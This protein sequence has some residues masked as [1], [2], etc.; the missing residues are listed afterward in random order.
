MLPQEITPQELKKRFEKKEEIQLIDVRTEDEVKLCQ[1]TGSVN[2]PLSS[3]AQHLN[4]IDPNVPIVTMCH[5]GVRSYQAACILVEN[6]F[7]LVKSLKGGI[8]AWSREVD[9]LV[10]RY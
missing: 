3:L 7:S 9:S 1:I 10:P 6:G 2:F 4:Q 8:D 5:H